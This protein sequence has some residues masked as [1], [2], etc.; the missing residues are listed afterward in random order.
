MFGYMRRRFSFKQTNKIIFVSSIFEVKQFFSGEVKPFF[1]EFATLL[2]ILFV[3]SLFTHDS[4]LFVL[5][6]T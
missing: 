1:G 2:V 3:I 5:F 6:C 4:F